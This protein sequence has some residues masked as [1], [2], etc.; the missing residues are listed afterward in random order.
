MSAETLLARLDGVQG[1]GPRWRAICPA[2]ESKHKTRSLAIFEA[3]DGRVL[4]RC[5][6]GCGFEQIV[7]AA[8]VEISDMFQPA[9]IG[10]A[11]PVRKPWSLRDVARALE[12]ESMIAWVVLSDMAAG[13]P[14]TKTDRAR[15]GVAADRCATLLREISGAA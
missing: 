12:A 13:K 9:P 3:E 8:G 14:I 2:H 1:R 5:F 4:V 11:P 10:N 6:A 15:A 7:A